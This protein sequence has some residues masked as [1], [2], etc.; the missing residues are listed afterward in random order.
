MSIRAIPIRLILICALLS[1]GAGQAAAP[2]TLQAMQAQ[3]PMTAAAWQRVIQAQT[4]AE[5]ANALHGFLRALAT[6]GLRPAA[7]TFDARDIASGR[8]VAPDDP[9]LLQRPQAHEVT[10][11]VDGR[12]YVF[13]PLSRASIEPMLRR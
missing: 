12:F 6:D 1:A 3:S 8:A 10:V 5:Q 7:L 4:A 2:P 13:R 11:A 9:A